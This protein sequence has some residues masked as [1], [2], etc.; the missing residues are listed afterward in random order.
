MSSL[1][2]Q[3]AEPDTAEREAFAGEVADV[4]NKAAPALL[5]GV[6]HQCGLFDTMAGLPPSTGADIAKAANLDERY[7]REWLG[8]MVVGGF[9]D[10]EPER[11]TYTQRAPRSTSVTSRRRVERPQPQPQPAVLS[12]QCSAL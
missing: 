4:L 1:E 2:M 9:V 8:G 12:P 6:G 10:H 5:T 11:Q 3:R 7:V